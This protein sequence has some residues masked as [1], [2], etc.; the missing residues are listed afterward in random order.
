MD[1]FHCTAE[2]ERLVIRPLIESDF[3][4]W[5]AQFS[6]R[7]PSQHRYDRGKIDMSDC[8]PEWF[9]GLVEKHQALAQE[10][11]AYIFGVFH[12]HNGTHLGMIDFST[13]ERSVFQWGR[14]GYTIHNQFWRNGYGKE[15]VKAALELAFSDLGYHRIEA[16][17]NV[18]NTPSYQL[19]AS[20][21]MEYEC[22]R[23]GFIFEFGEWT[24]NLV[25]YINA[26]QAKGKL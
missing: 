24:D 11:K 8:S 19:A 6:A 4:N 17:I 3:Q 10:D 21:G 26:E 7:M 5:F 2:T 13:Y 20:V 15:A 22:T 12:K 25:Y 9:S 23:K 18:D 16:H 14:L 1:N